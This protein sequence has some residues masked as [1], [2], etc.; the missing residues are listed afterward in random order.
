[1]NHSPD[2][3]E[4]F[5]LL[6][7]AVSDYA[8]YMLDTNG[9]VTNWNRGAELIK[10][11]S[12]EEII[13][14]HFSIFY[15]AEERSTGVPA[16]ALEESLTVGRF[17]AEGW[18]ERKDGARY[19]ASVVV[20]PVFDDEG[21]HIGFAKITRDISDRRLAQEALVQ[22]ERQFRLLVE[23]VIDYALY[24]LDP[25]GIVTNWNSGAQRIKGYSAEEIVGRHFSTFYTETD[26][27]AG[28]PQRA[29]RTA[30]QEGRFEADGWRV[31]KDG[32][33]FWASV[34]IDAIRDETGQLVGF[35][36]ITRDITER[37]NAQLELQKAQERLALAQKMEAI[38]QLTGGVAHDFNNLL[39]VV[40]GQA[41]LLRKRIGDDPRVLASLD[42]IEQ[43]SKRGQD[44]TRHLL[45]FARRQR[46]QPVSMSLLDRRAGLKDLL[47]A[48]L[49]PRITVEV[50]L[51]PDLW[52]LEVDIGELELAL[53]NMAVN[54]RDAM[55]DAGTLR[56]SASNAHLTGREPELDVEGDFVAIE[57]R[58]DGAGIPPDILPHVFDPFFTTKSVNKGTGLGLSQVYGFVQQSGGR[59]VVSSVLGAGTAFTIYLPRAKRSPIEL[60]VAPHAEAPAGLSILL[61]ED[62]PDVADVAAQ[63]LEQLGNRVAVANGAEAALAMLEDGL[64]PDLVFSDVVMAGAL[65]GIELG[66]RIRTQWPGLPVILATGY[67]EAAE[68]IGPEF[69]ILA[70]P[71]QL[72]E[73]S[74]LLGAT[75]AKEPPPAGT[76]VSL[77][78]RKRSGAKS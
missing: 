8:I 34:V 27:T 45:S 53:L 52:P 56:V 11:Y 35:A 54:A 7:E 48:G 44:L 57:V 12:A 20:D 15:T 29:L 31:R 38:G 6:V 60:T 18:R 69:P 36:K 33:L 24:M 5:R 39:M 55:P 9:L 77:A 40:S 68:T 17:E 43:A 49:P 4:R 30:T 22:S 19:W 16:R 41:Q 25:N 73:L 13:G 2:S 64:K 58:D 26:R 72:D 28:R 67:A 70:K 14:R 62:N 78:A 61:V 1:V 63:L 71:Y 47:S 59:V 10:G 74:R 37:R 46:L 76:V 65:N 32:T 23:G 42:A 75:F 66:R 50:D 51:D 3:D 21:R